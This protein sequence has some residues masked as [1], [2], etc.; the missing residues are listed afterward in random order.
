MQGGIFSPATSHG[1]GP[2][3][4]I[5]GTVKREATRTSL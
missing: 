5:E 3:D 2:S 4:K 1:K